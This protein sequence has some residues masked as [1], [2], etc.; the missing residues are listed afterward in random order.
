MERE[1]AL[2]IHVDGENRTIQGSERED[3]IHLHMEGKIGESL[4]LQFTADQDAA[5]LSSLRF[6]DGHVASLKTIRQRG[7]GS[8]EREWKDGI[9]LKGS[10][11]TGGP[12]PGIGL[13]VNRPDAAGAT[14]AVIEKGRPYWEIPEALAQSGTRDRAAV[15]REVTWGSRLSAHLE[16]AWNRYG[17]KQVSHA[18]ESASASGAVTWSLLRE[19]GVMLEYYVDG[20]Y[21]LSAKPALDAGG[22]RFEPLPLVTHEVHGARVGFSKSVNRNIRVSGASGIAVD[23]FGGHAPFVN[24]SMDYAPRGHFGGHISFDRSLYY[25]DSARTVTTFGA[26]FYWRF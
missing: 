17:L 13:T 11:F 24:L 21:R 4:R 7:E 26:G 22:N 15:R 23:R 8:L 10:I 19:P 2:Q 5:S 9:R 25:L 6:T 3:L 14:T 20:E 1:Q 12:A 18:A 16:A